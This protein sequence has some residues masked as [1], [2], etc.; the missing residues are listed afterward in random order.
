MANIFL[1]KKC[2]LNCSYCFADE[3][4]NKE[5]EEIT[6]E[7][8][9]F[10]LDFIKTNKEERIG[11]IGGEPLLHS[12]FKEILNI[13]L[14]DEQV[15]NVILYTN[16]IEIDKYIDLIQDSKIS[17]LVNCNSSKDIGEQNYN[18]LKQNIQ[19]LRDI[20]KKNFDLG[21]NL[22]SKN[23]DYSY[24]FEL[25]KLAD[26]KRVRFSTAL[27]NIYKESAENV[28]DD[29]YDFKPFLFEFLNTCVNEEIVANNDCNSV[30]SCILNLDEI[31]ILLKL[32][33]L[34]AFYNAGS[35]IKT[36]NICLPVIDILPDLTAIRCFGMSKEERVSIKKYKSIDS[37]RKY[38]FNKIDIFARV[39]YISQNCDDCK[40]RLSDRCG[41]CFTYKMNQI[42]KLKNNMNVK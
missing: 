27:P 6:I 36:S 10:A 15:C 37:L 4:V 16:G 22:Y 20:K 41:V 34:G 17:V 23:L 35:P 38:F 18:K 28:L 39:S 40:I 7:D 5:I 29:F 3:F 26:L 9:L 21:I 32:N 24:I 2:N 11:L 13:L 31:R 33:Q 8:F 14:E 30:P 42:N 1:T 12:K 19:L 25:L